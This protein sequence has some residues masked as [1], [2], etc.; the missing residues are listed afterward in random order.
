[1]G[2]RADTRGRWIALAGSLALRCADQPEE[3]AE[4]QTNPDGG[5]PLACCT[6]CP[7]LVEGCR[8]PKPLSAFPGESTLRRQFR[9]HCLDSA[10]SSADR[11]SDYSSAGRCSN[12]LRY[13]TFGDGLSNETHY[14][15]PAGRFVGLE[16]FSDFSDEVCSGRWYWPWPID[17]GERTLVE[18]LCWR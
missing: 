18:R 16:G 12:G 2:A 15:D 7:P 11:C 5:L 9:D 1:M 8:D 10:D 17:C 6:R 14:F 4:C 13:I 3:P